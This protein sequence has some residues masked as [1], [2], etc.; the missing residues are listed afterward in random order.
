LTA[1]FEALP[2]DE[3]HELIGQARQSNPV[4]RERPEDHPLVRAAAIALLDEN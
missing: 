1:E 2:D 4:L 3:Q